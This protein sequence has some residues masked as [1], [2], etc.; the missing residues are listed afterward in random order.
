M[1]RRIIHFIFLL[2]SLFI[3]LFIYMLKEN[4]RT[5]INFFPIDDN[6]YFKDAYT[7]LTL[8]S[9]TNKHADEVYWTSISKSSKA[10]YLRQDVSIIFLNGKLT[11]VRSKWRE[12]TDFIEVKESIHFKKKG[13][14]QAISYHHGE[15]HYNES[16]IKSVQQMSYDELTFDLNQNIKKH[17]KK[18]LIIYWN[19]LLDHF[20]I[21]VEKYMSVPFVDLYHYNDKN[22]PSLSKRQTDKIIGQL[23]E[24]FY[25]NYIIPVTNNKNSVEDNLMPLILFDN[26]HHHL[27]IIFELNGKKEML[28][29]QYSH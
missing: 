7:K 10:L 15:A 24:G 19:D 22:L 2:A 13:L 14:Y 9:T 28:I 16:D 25:E 26:H 18:Q 20:N 11:G 21:N 5:T 3:I 27:L 8:Q 29:Q 1:S 23:W 4:T 17:D 12:N 6:L